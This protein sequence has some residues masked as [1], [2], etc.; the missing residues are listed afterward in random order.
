MSRR[1]EPRPRRVLLRRCETGAEAA[2]WANAYREV[3]TSLGIAA[4]WRVRIDR[5]DEG[6]LM[7]GVDYEPRP[8]GDAR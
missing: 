2:I 3:L 4:W 7:V 6:A 5:A 1:R 8:P